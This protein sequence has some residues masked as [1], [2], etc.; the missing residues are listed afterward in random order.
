MAII[1]RK[2]SF[3]LATILTLA[4]TLGPAV[5]EQTIVVVDVNAALTNSKAGKSMASQ[6]ESQMKVLSDDA[7]KFEARMTG[8]VEKLKEQSSLMAPDARQSRVEE[9][10]LEKLQTEQELGKRQRA[11]QAGGQKA[12]QEILKVALEELRVIAEQ[13]NADLVV[14]RDAVL[15]SSPSL[16]VTKDVVSAID[17]KLSN[18]KVNPIEVKE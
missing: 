13:R 17:K 7:Q 3:V 16:D 14:R 1:N 8:E 4:T 6:L 12:G 9:L 15:I 10:R 2:L 11:I 5:A 18:V